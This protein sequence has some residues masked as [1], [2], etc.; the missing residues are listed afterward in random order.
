METQDK[1]QIELIVENPVFGLGYFYAPLYL[2]ATESDV[3][4]AIQRARGF[5]R[6]DRDEDISVTECPRLPALEDTRL[7]APTI[8]ELNFFAGRLEELPEE[9]LTVLNAVFKKRRD[10]GSFDDGITMKDLINLTY[11][12][13]SVPTASNVSSDEALG[14]LVI[15]SEMNEDVNSVPEDA[16]YLLDKARIGRLQRQNEDG[17][18]LSGQYVPTCHYEMPEVYDGVHLPEKL[19]TIPDGFWLQIAKGP[20]DESKRPVYFIDNPDEKAIWISLPI[21]REEADGFARE[22]GES[23]VEDCVF[24]GFESAIPQIDSEKFGSMRNF[25]T[26]NEIASRFTAMSEP[27]QIKYKAVLEAH[28]FRWPVNTLMDALDAARHIAEYELSYFSETAGDFSK[29]Y[30]SYHLPTGF[31]TEWLKDVQTNRM[32]ID[33]LDRLGAR[34]TEYGVVSARGKSLFELVPF[35]EPQNKELK[36]QAMTDEKLEVVEVLGQTALFSNGRY[37]EAEV[38][39]GLYKYELREGESISFATI[40]KSVAVNHGGTV[41]TKAPLDFGGETYFVF[42]DDSSPNF[43]GYEM[44]A[45]EFLN[46]DVTQ[47]ENQENGGPRL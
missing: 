16:R 23:R 25:D 39:E 6:K 35:E 1:M 32:G 21:D 14:Q 28:V 42:D 13:G 8:R 36:T 4:D 47:Q 46:T 30:L 31:D 29:A 3:R 9:E 18:Y 12:L 41:F 7:D 20:F 5:G 40:E 43:L 10:A 44:T 33:L 24:Y 27:E 45:G 2:P 22:L 38:P 37:T 17:V 34:C 19:H 26:F 15:D 11:G